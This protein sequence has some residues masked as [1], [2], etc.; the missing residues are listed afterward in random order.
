V[1]LKIYDLAG[2]LVAT[3]VEGATTAGTHQVLWQPAQQAAGGIYWAVLRA[4]TN[5]AA[6]EEM[7]TRKVLLLK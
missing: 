5:L 6:N 2:R 1:S 3:L 7:S 4:R